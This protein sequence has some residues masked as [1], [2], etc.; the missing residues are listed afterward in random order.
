M[1]VI[2]PAETLSPADSLENTGQTMIPDESDDQMSKW[3]DAYSSNEDFFG[4]DASQL[5]RNALIVFQSHSATK[6][7]ELGCGQGRDTLYLAQNGMKV[8]GMDYSETGLCQIRDRAAS[9]GVGGSIVLK[10]G[11][12][13]KGLPFEDG[14]FDG[15]F[16]HMFFTMHF[17]EKELSF[18]FSEV[19]RVLKPGGLSVYSVRNVAD[20]HF[21]KG[22]H[23]GEDMW[24]NPLGF[25][26]HFFDEE[27][28]RRL[29]AGYDIL[30]IKE[31]DDLTPPFT[32][33][34]FEVALQK[35]RDF[36]KK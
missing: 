27:K 9:K 15:C 1:D 14:S 32:K 33:K 25:V 29:A 23:F 20:P 17:P 4:S 6:I 5:G 19:L 35:P 12:A 21:G 3:D 11:D 13:R 31:F 30:W 7:L 8:T 10:V 16:S 26:V 22:R 24:Q 34:L 36:K 18:I 2:H 28:V